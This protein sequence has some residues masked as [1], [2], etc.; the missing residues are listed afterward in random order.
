VAGVCTLLGA[1]VTGVDACRSFVNDVLPQSARWMGEVASVGLVAVG[2]DLA[3]PVG[4]RAAMAAGAAWVV[5]MLLRRVRT[6]DQ[7]WGLG[8]AGSL[9]ISP[10]SWSYYLMLAVP[11][12]ALVAGRLDWR[13]PGA[14]LLV[15]SV[16][17]L[18]YYWPSLSAYWPEKQGGVAGVVLGMLMRLP[19]VAL[20]VLTAWC[21]RLA[22]AGPGANGGL[23]PVGD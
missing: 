9:L 13:R 3:G 18:L 21:A 17:V 22:D 10:L 2:H 7:A 16:C 12:L 6:A 8:L 19:A 11:V 14:R 15:L 20:V 5:W 4:G 23:E 1:A